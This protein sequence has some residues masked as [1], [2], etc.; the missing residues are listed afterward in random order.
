MTIS[1]NSMATPIL[2]G[3]V[4]LETAQ[5][6]S[7]EDLLD[8]AN[9]FLVQNNAPSLQGLAE[10]RVQSE[11]SDAYPDH[12]LPAAL[13]EFLLRAGADAAFMNKNFE[14]SYRLEHYAS[15]RQF[16]DDFMEDFSSDGGASALHCVNEHGNLHPSI[17]VIA[18]DVMGRVFYCMDASNNDS[19]VFEL[20][21]SESTVKEVSMSM[22]AFL[23]LE[24]IN[25]YW[26]N[27]TSTPSRN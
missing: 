17:A 15:N 20:K 22:L 10:D 18:C 13:K 5:W 14:D 19:P 9:R 11:W 27:C 25:Y 21:A 23:R 8:E 4:S 24:L 2:H 1:Q 3:D 7:I 12:E 16:A 6:K 26:A